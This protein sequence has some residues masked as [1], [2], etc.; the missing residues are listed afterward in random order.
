MAI[1]LYQFPT[2]LGMPNLS[3]FCMKVET[4][5]R[6]AKLPYEIRWTPNPRKGPVGKLPYIV[7]DGETICDSER[8]FA[9]LS[10][11]HGIDLDAKLTS[12]QKAAARAFQRMLDEHTYWGL[13]YSRWLDPAAWRSYRRAFFA[14][15]P[16]PLR[17]PV[18]S[19]VQRQVRRD[20]WSQGL[21]RH[22][23]AEL[24]ARI[25]QDFQALADG[26]G[27]KPFLMGGEPTTVD[28]SVYAIVGNAWEATAETPLKALVGR[29]P[30][31]VAYCARMRER[32]FG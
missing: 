6:L 28:A 20:A 29:H 2:G 17:K 30:N 8:I 21:A 27:D 7:D 11:K 18:S 3:P 25:A 15:L 14:A 24:Y 5:L 31:L 10:R 4:F 22:P 23:P 12:E 19:L 13:L 26:L 16:A 32:C 1:Q 9:H